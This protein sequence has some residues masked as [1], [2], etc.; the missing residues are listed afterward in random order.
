[1]AE[2]RPIVSEHSSKMGGIFGS[3]EMANRLRRG[4]LFLDGTWTQ[5]NIELAGYDLRIAA[6]LM[7]VPNES[8]GGDRRYRLGEYRRDP[9]ILKPGQ[10]ARF[11][12][13]EHFRLPLN[14]CGL[15]SVR[16]SYA[17]RG[18][19]LLTGPVVEP[20]FGATGAVG[21]D[22]DQAGIPPRLNF[23]VANVGNRQLVILPGV[24]SI[25]TVQFVSVIEAPD[26]ITSAKRK[27]KDKKWV[28]FV[29][30]ENETDLSEGALGLVTRLAD[31]QATY[32]GLSRR[33]EEVRTG[34][35][36]F[37]QLGWIVLAAAFLGATFTSL[38]AIAANEN[39]I[40]QLH[41]LSSA[42]GG[43]WQLVGVIWAVLLA[44]GLAGLAAT[45]VL[46]GIGRML[47]G[48]N[49]VTQKMK[50]DSPE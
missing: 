14:V 9:V 30:D 16:F 43:G 47:S 6:D 20:G 37:I 10:V 13:V 8:G 36:P 19:L 29:G 25:A 49:N 17:S 34:A 42:V 21:E 41:K 50:A 3:T 33:I 46:A 1:M 7:V 45:R 15:I 28:Q 40:H 5:D 18:L 39:T 26:H 23:F 32:A 11:S 31:M 2:G 22:I 44:L 27:S 12:S 24:T 4:Q 35:L 48:R 38:T